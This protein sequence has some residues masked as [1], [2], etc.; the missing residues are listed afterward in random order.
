MVVLK[1]FDAVSR[2]VSLVLRPI[3]TKPVIFSSSCQNRKSI[4]KN[5]SETIRSQT[6]CVVCITNGANLLIS[7]HT[8]SCLSHLKTRTDTEYKLRVSVAIKA[9][10]SV[11][12]LGK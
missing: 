1:L 7:V 2:F 5:V 11:G 4:S 9:L 6:I 12:I 10:M 3:F 8:N